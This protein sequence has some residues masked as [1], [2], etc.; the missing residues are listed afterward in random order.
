MK[1]IPQD[2]SNTQTNWP[3]YWPLPNVDIEKNMLWNLHHGPGSTMKQ[4]S[5]TR[6]WQEHEKIFLIDCEDI[7]IYEDSFINDERVHLFNPAVS[8][9]DRQYLWLFWYDYCTKIEK[10]MKLY[11]RCLPTALKNPKFIFDSLLGT[12]HGRYHKHFVEQKILEHKHKSKFCTGLKNP[13]VCMDEDKKLDVGW[14]SGGDFDKGNKRVRHNEGPGNVA[15]V[16]RFIPYSIY[17][18]SYYSLVCETRGE[19]YP[20]LTEKTAKPLL[21]KRIFVIFGS[22]GYLQGIK[23]IGFETFS[24]ILD[25]SY[26]LIDDP[27]TRWNK[28]WEQIEFL[29]DQDPVLLYKKVDNILEH[30]YNLMINNAWMQETVTKIEELCV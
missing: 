7:S 21:A 8:D 15:N 3:A 18:N 19:R 14:V 20:F 6:S 24:D 11:H 16:C 17:N 27:E 28:A 22:K 10:D 13:N 5:T 29:I 9:V 25:E 30:N 2:I 26:D 23:N 4:L 12:M 1:P